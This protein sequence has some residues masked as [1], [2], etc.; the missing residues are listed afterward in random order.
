MVTPS[1]PGADFLRGSEAS[2]RSSSYILKSTC[3]SVIWGLPC[4]CHHLRPGGSLR[5]AG[6]DGGESCL[7]ARSSSMAALDML[8]VR[9][10]PATGLHRPGLLHIV[11]AILHAWVAAPGSIEGLA[12]LFPPLSSGPLSVPF[13]KGVLATVLQSALVGARLK[14]HPPCLAPL[15]LELQPVKVRVW[16]VNRNTHYLL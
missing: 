6:G 9:A 11:L 13:K 12:L 15:C 14:G 10:I 1:A 5:A 8:R 2:A 7:S 4:Q 3:P 16:A